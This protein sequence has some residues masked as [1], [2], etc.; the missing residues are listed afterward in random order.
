M[1]VFPF[2][3]YIFSILFLIRIKD[4][5]RD[6]VLQLVQKICMGL[7]D[8]WLLRVMVLSLRAVSCFKEHLQLTLVIFSVMYITNNLFV[9]CEYSC[10]II[11]SSSCAP[12][13]YSVP[14]MDQIFIYL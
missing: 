2:S 10:E 12:V 9:I 1:G 14:N 7:I 5:T 4:Y 13:L 3:A 8:I 6:P 11:M